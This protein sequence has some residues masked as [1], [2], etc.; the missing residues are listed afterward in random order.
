MKK[1]T[2]LAIST[3]AAAASFAV[4]PASAS[5]QSTMAYPEKCKSQGM[6]MSKMDMSSAGMPMGE[7][8]D[9]Q[10]ASM[11]GMK[12]M[13]MNMMQGMMKKDADLSFVCGMI[14]HH[15]GAIS[16]SEVELKYGDN[17]EAKQMAQKVIE[18]QKKEI[19]EMSKWVDKEAK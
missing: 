19:E 14:A 7:M 17:D 2:T 16:M 18:A 10:K 1:L 15:M 4:L 9:Y 3:V 12:D 13:H 5:A 8:T 6:D 11:E